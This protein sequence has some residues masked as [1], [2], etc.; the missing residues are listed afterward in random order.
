M[1]SLFVN[2]SFAFLFIFIFGFIMF[3][4]FERADNI[5]SSY[6]KANNGGYRE[7]MNI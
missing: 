2:S 5:C 7:C 1:K 3:K 4:G 6:S